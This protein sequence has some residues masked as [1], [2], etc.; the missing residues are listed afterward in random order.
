[1]SG[2]ACKIHGSV[3]G[4]ILYRQVVMKTALRQILVSIFCAYPIRLL[5]FPFVSP[6]SDSLSLWLPSLGQFILD[7]WTFLT[8]A[9][10]STP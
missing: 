2:E 8:L 5:S 1:M 7:R 10:T 6:S 4:P 9:A 3:C